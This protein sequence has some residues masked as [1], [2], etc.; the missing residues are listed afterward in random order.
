MNRKLL[1]TLLRKDIQELEMITE[2]FMEMNE[3]PK[4][5]ILLAQRKAEDIQQYIN[6]LAEIR[7]KLTD[8]EDNS[9][10]IFHETDVAQQQFT[11]EPIIE[12]DT[13]DEIQEEILSAQEFTSELI[14]VEKPTDQS[15]ESTDEALIVEPIEF[16][17]GEA[18]I[19]TEV[20]TDEIVKITIDEKTRSVSA[21]RNE[22]LSKIDNS[23]SSILANKK[24]IDIKQAISI[25]DRFR[26]QRELFNANGEDMNK[27]LT[28]INQLATFEEVQSFL[29]SKY[30]WTEENEAKE[31][32]YQI[33]RRRFL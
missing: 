10:E 14:E 21:S 18:E 6:Q 16:N 23:I 4:T 20:I 9:A 26:F 28:Y 17:F 5:I 1:V 30:K 8:S 11:P 31:D 7:V 15:S 3:Y 2:G 24:I 29:E 13:K 27:T 22:T 19:E 12:T 33:A 25:G 32:F